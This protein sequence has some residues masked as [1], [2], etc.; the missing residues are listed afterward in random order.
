MYHGHTCLKRRFS[1]QNRILQV[2]TISRKLQER[3]NSVFQ[4]WSCYN[5]FLQH[6]KSSNKTD[7]LS[8]LCLSDVSVA[9]RM[10]M[11]DVQTIPIWFC[12]FLSW[13]TTTSLPQPFLDV[14]IPVCVT[15]PLYHDE[16]FGRG[17]QW[18][19]TLNLSNS[20]TC[21][22]QQKVKPLL[23]SY[24]HLFQPLL[25]CLRGLICIPFPARRATRGLPEDL[26]SSL[27][28]I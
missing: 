13:L 1:I 15:Q 17:E 16:P 5:I 14:S 21:N 11:H 20:Y 3:S 25:T 7:F 10:G 6:A 2:C 27:M 4:K 19:K 9:L 23:S 8:Q 28:N 22:S 12:L 18:S 24:Y 26:P